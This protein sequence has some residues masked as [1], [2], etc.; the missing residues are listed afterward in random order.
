[1]LT[2]ERLK[3]LF[4]NFKKLRVLIIG[5]VMT[6][7]YIWGSVKRLSPEAP[8]PIV[9]VVKRE[10]RPG[11]AAN[12]ALNIKSLGAEPILCGVV[13]N[14]AKGDAFLDLLKAETLSPHGIL[15]SS[16]RKTTVKFR[17][18]GN[19]THLL[20]VDEET[21]NLLT[22]Q[23]S[24]E[25]LKIIDKILAT[26]AI[27]VIVFEDYDKGVLSKKLLEQVITRSKA[28]GIPIVADPKKHNFFNYKEIQ[29][30]K[31]NF[32]ELVQ[33]LKIDISPKHHQ[34]LENA[35]QAFQAKQC[36]NCVIVSLSEHGIYVSEKTKQGFKTKH[37]PAHVRNIADVSGAGDTLISVVALCA[38][39]GVNAFDTAALSNVAGGI[40]CEDVG[41]VPI[42]K[43]KLFK[44]AL[45]LLL[46]K[47]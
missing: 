7:A 26:E 40:V 25:L 16:H 10:N 46:K 1:M 47:A 34:A 19:N 4:D 15:Q 43:E 27:D 2:T 8:V 11:G 6:D 44:E 22:P 36:I 42:S 3:K 29:Y 5:D 23:E 38:A 41:V 20:R 17:V 14:D 9:D 33:G 39:A 24:K 30:F 21:T 37:I 35:V 31:P 18:I 45:S 32:K 13:G 12:V 28:A